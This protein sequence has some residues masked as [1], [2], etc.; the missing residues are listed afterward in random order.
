MG[1]Q[2]VISQARL[3]TRWAWA[4]VIT[5]KAQLTEQSSQ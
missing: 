5:V 2:P 1:A 3:G 4:D